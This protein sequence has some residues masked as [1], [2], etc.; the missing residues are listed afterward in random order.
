MVGGKYKEAG[1][2]LKEQ[3]MQITAL[4]RRITELQTLKA[5]VSNSL[6]MAP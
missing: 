4:N 3:R 2:N 5:G 6:R 1:H